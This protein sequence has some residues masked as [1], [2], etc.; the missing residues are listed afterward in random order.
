MRSTNYTNAIS[1]EELR[2]LYFKNGLSMKAIATELECSVHKVV[3]WMDKYAIK[4]RA[5]SDA[6]YLKNNPDG[7]PFKLK[8]IET[9]EDA[10]LFGMGVGL[11]WGEGTKSSKHSVRLGN[12]D[13]VLLNEFIRFLVT[14][15]GVSKDNLRFGLQIFTDIDAEL[16]LEY[17]VRELNV[18]PS[19]FYKII[20][21]ISGSLGTYRK[22]SEYGVVTVH[23][24][25]KKLR[26][27]LVD[28]CR[29]SS[30]GRAQLW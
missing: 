6:I 23:Y 29:G 22:K 17:W 4:R 21:T 16:A 8:E 24:H 1:E 18:T 30:V 11:Y 27:I 7:D 26:D 25:N 2:K 5:I 14:L 3:Y 10:R 15:C 13:P 19:Q 12:T 9:L 20:V 28:I